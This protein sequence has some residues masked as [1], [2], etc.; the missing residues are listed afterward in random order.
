MIFLPF[1]SLSKP[2]PQPKSTSQPVTY[3]YNTY[4][5]NSNAQGGQ[6]LENSNENV[7][8]AVAKT[9]VAIE[10]KLTTDIKIILKKALESSTKTIKNK[11]NIAVDFFNKNKYRI[12]AGGITAVYFYLLYKV[13]QCK[14]LMRNTESWCCWR[15]ELDTD[16]LLQ[17]PY[18][19]VY[20][21]LLRDIQA[22]YIIN[23]NN[24]N[25]LDPFTEFVQE[26]KYEINIL[27][28]YLMIHKALGIFRVKKLFFTNNK[29]A[30]LAKD[31][32]ERLYFIYKS[33]IAWHTS[34]NIQ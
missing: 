9:E 14:S 15:P 10:N 8:K 27:S 23:Q 20:E 7:N 24:I 1:L 33:F 5:N 11:K 31:K 30:D 4:F 28:K 16:D 25:F 12:L 13:Q 19:A 32:L 22:K 21:R 34:R 17:K 26:I 29:T 3:V 18:H 2:N 6:S